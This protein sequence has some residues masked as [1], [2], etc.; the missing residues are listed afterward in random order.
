MCL[1]LSSI[2]GQGQRE[3]RPGSSRPGRTASCAGRRPPQSRPPSP[4]ARPPRGRAPPGHPAPARTAPA[5]LMEYRGRLHTGSSQRC[6][7]N[8]RSSDTSLI[9]SV[10]SPKTHGFIHTAPANR[11][12]KA[13]RKNFCKV[14]GLSKIVL[15]RALDSILG[16]DGSAQV[17]AAG[18]L[19]MGFLFLATLSLILGVSFVHEVIRKLQSD[20]LQYPAFGSQNG[21]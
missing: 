12:C 8:R 13:W 21:P 1:P 16:P 4:G 10:S 18:A 2:A 20:G 5:R 3:A 14:Q 7:P 17:P 15:T 9:S 19:Q 6:F 11:P